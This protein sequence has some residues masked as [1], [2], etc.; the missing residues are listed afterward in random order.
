MARDGMGS[1]IERVRVLADAG[2]AEWTLGTVTY[3]SDDLIEDRLDLHRVEYRES[4]SP[5]GINVDGTT[6]Y[7]DYQLSYGQLEEAASGTTAWQVR[8]AGGTLQGTAT[9][10]VNYEAGKV[11]FTADTDGSIFYF[12]YRAYDVY[13][14]AADIWRTR[15]ANVH[16]YYTV[17]EGEH[18]LSRSDMFKHC[19]LMAGEMDKQA[20]GAGNL[21]VRMYRSD[22]N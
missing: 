16:K 19:M 18:S 14:A 13:A 10:D 17:R 22:L 9:Y 3:W 21:V 7:H 5:I 2:T 6:E 4:A 12:W 8:S 1:L 15:A 20:G 11:R